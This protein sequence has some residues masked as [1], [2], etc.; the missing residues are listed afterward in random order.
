VVFAVLLL[1]PV[2]LLVGSVS[3]I[4]VHRKLWA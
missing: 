4:F 2:V 3:V 1:G